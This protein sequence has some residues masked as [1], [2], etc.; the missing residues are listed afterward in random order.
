M[1]FL[2][3]FGAVIFGVYVGWVLRETYATH[4]LNKVLH[5]VEENVKQIAK[6][7]IHINIE[8]HNDHFYV[9]NKETNT[10]M[11]QAGS[12]EELEEILK[13]RFPGKNFACSEKVLREIG[14]LS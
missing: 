12:K 10:F 4:V 13:D 8:K 14:F 3:L 11:A 9:Y 6:D 7:A 2:I 1:E 5:N